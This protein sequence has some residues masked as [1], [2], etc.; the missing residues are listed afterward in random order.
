M[1]A[2]STELHSVL[3]PL[4][5][6]MPPLAEREG[7]RLALAHAMLQELAVR[8][9]LEPPSFEAGAKK[10]IETQ[11]WPGNLRQMR[12]VLIAVLNSLITGATISAAQ[13]EIALARLAPNPRNS[14]TGSGKS[15]IDPNQLLGSDGFSLNAL[16][17]SLYEIAMV[18][19]QGNLSAA[20]RML[21]LTRAQLAYRI[22]NARRSK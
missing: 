20:A 18:Q 2:F 16:E 15:A 4:H 8:M 11:L 12:G 13:I 9:G 21:G 22:D 1:P 19:A 3:S 10:L 5:V 17:H 7:E 14:A 6:R